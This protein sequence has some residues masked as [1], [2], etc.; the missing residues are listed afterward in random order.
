[1]IRTEARFA[2]STR[3]G[4][5]ST[6]WN[7]RGLNEEA[8]LATRMFGCDL[9]ISLHSS[10]AC[11]WSATDHWVRSQPSAR[12][13]DRHIVR[14]QVTHPHGPESLLLLRVAIPVS[15]VRVLPHPT[16]RKKDPRVEGAPPESTV[17]FLSSLT[18]RHDREPSA[19]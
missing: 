16:D 18:R 6:I 14:W 7:A 1:M 15:E 2:V 3:T 12:N 8:Y 10:G 19:P 5:R 9:K 4:P 13:A 17:Q 11:H